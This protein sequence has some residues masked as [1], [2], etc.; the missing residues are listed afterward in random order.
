LFLANVPFGLAVPLFVV[1]APPDVRVAY[2]LDLTGT[3]L[4]VLAFGLFVVGVGSLGIGD[5]R[6]AMGEIVAGVF[7]F[8]LFVRQQLQ[9]PKPM[10]PFDLFRIV[11]FAASMWISVC[12]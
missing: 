2:A 6:M 10:L 7:C 12:S 8:G 11:P 5:E 9:H 3:A 1:T 4:N